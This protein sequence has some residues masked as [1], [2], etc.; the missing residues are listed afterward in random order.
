MDYPKIPNSTLYKLRE[1]LEEDDPVRLKAFLEDD[2]SDVWLSEYPE[3]MTECLSSGAKKCAFLMLSG[4]VRHGIGE[5]SRRDVLRQ[6]LE[7]RT[8][9]PEIVE[10]L[11]ERF[12][13]ERYANTLTRLGTH[14]IHDFI[15]M[16]TRIFPV[17]TWI[18]DGSLFKLLI[19]LCDPQLRKK[20][21]CLRLLA[22][23]THSL[24]KVA[25]S[26]LINGDVVELAA[27]L[28]VA[29][30][31]LLHHL[32]SCHIEN[33]PSTMKDTSEMV[34]LAAVGKFPNPS[35]FGLIEI[36]E[37]AG[38]SLT[39]FYTK[40]PQ[41]ISGQDLIKSVA[42][43]LI[44][45]AQIP[46]SEDDV[47]LAG[48]LSVEPEMMPSIHQ[49]L[50]GI[51]PKDGSDKSQKHMFPSVRSPDLLYLWEPVKGWFGNISPAQLQGFCN[52]RSGHR[53]GKRP[54]STAALQNLRKT[55]KSQACF[56][57]PPTPALRVMASL[58]MRLGRGLRFL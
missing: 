41:D 55:A 34:S 3:V 23:Y 43:I 19:L 13:G 48:I 8:C 31:S 52:A 4:D 25:A 53:M 47:D 56:S 51:K 49:Y 35:G 50:L 57:P 30:P 12:G 44:R 7:I 15:S 21:H 14:P 42:E 2:E 1:I 24:P 9:D 33:H 46:V 29:H 22:N 27:L 36:F 28:L 11:F 5:Y 26:F 20:L 18:R 38:D 45:D 16:L 40:M 58:A 37:K 32:K 54:Y 39:N 17:C 6:A 10:V